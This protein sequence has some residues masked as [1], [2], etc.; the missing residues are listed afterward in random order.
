MVQERAIRESASQAAKQEAYDATHPP[1]P[2]TPEQSWQRFEMEQRLSG[3]IP[4]P[5]RPSDYEMMQRLQKQ[6]GD[7]QG[8]ETKCPDSADGPC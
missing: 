6:I 3:A 7:E 4:P 1:T 2:L 8:T 5:K